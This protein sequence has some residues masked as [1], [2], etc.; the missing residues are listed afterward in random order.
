MALSQAVKAGLLSKEGRHIIGRGGYSPE[1]AF[2]PVTSEG[3]YTPAHSFGAQVAEVAVDRETGQVRVVQMGGA[4]DCGTPIN[5]MHV[6]GQVEGA[7]IG[8]LGQAL[9]E[10]LVTEGGLVMNPSLLEYKVPTALDVPSL[11]IALVDNTDPEGPFGAKGIAE[12]CQIASSPAIANAIDHAV[13]IRIKDLP[14]TPEK[15]LEALRKKENDA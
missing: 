11:P 6:E 5:P 15:I 2:N 12:G 3:H 9:Y 7:T 8:G 1:T 4:Y 14:I 13:G 10:N